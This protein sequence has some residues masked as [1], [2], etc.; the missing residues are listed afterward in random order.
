MG[1]AAQELVEKTLR[2][3]TKAETLEKLASVITSARVLP[4]YYFTAAQWRKP[5][6]IIEALSKLGWLN[7][8]LAVRS[9][10]LGE[11]GAI[12]S[13]AGHFVSVLHVE[14]EAAIRKA[15]ERVIASYAAPDEGHQ[16]LV[17]PML[18]HA[19]L[20]GVA[21]TCD[22][23][24]GGPYRVINYDA[25][26]GA[27]D[28]V[29]GG[30]DAPLE[31]YYCHRDAPEAPHGFLGDVVR[32]CDE[33]EQRFNSAAIDIE[34]AVDA[35]DRL[36]LLQARPLA[37]AR[38]AEPLPYHGEA[39]RRASAKIA[40]AMRPHPYLYGKR[41]V[42][43]VMPDWNP[44]EIVGIRPRPLA[45]SLYR[46]L[47]TDAIWA[48]QRDNYGYH[49][50]RGFPLL[51]D[52]EGLPYIDVRVSFNSFVPKTLNPALAARLVE[53]YTDR[54]IAD[55][56]LHDKVEFDIVFTCYT[57]DLRERLTVLDAY[58]FNADEREQIA[59][60][61]TDLTKRIV[62]KNTGLWRQDSAK[63]EKLKLRRATLEGSGMDDITCLHWL[64]EDCKRYGTLP[65]AGLA[66]AGFIAVQ[67]LRSFVAVGILNEHEYHQFFASV[68]SVSSRMAADFN[69]M[70][71][72]EFLRQYGHLRP[73]T[74]DILSARYDEMPDMYFDWSEQSEPCARPHFALSISQLRTLQDHIRRDG[75]PLDALELLEFI[76]TAI[77]AREYSKFVFTRSVSDFL[78]RLERFA[79][80]LGISREALSYVNVDDVLALYSRSDDPAQVLKRSAEAG[81]ARFD[82]TRTLCMPPLITS[83]EDVWAFAV[84]A[85]APNFITQKSVEARVAFVTEQD[86]DLEGAVV[87]IPSADPGYDWIFGHGIAGLITTYGGVNSHMAIRAGELSIPAVIGAGERLYQQWAAAYILHVDCQNRQVRIVR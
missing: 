57:L 32:L 7:I 41:S 79:A 11:D 20:S 76:K 9:S 71:R 66:R 50:L 8:P 52:F 10:A 84:P 59:T 72:E 15:V 49:N 29:T 40:A 1:R 74:Y 53:Y 36:V 44:A 5:D 47:V 3:G 31:S 25:V 65:F 64:L 42:F 17:Q 27:T 51:H 34:F 85:C 56:S 55:P 33:L 24:S 83:P 73:G 39:V 82:L 58:G 67:M 69:T 62:D 18:E 22:P 2:F 28:S 30:Q 23:N 46:Q 43:G 54:L 78:Q 63:I 12:A 70:S 48:Y 75:L 86:A 37:A 4:L 16:V 60:A 45:L 6:N 26:S 81:R 19:K 38:D 13:F 61:L 68:D 80:P 21:F 77:E 87:F 14:G 35:Q